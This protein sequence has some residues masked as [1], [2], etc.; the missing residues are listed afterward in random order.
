M[1]DGLLG[2]IDRT[3]EDSVQVSVMSLSLKTLREREM[4]M[5]NWAVC[6]WKVLKHLGSKVDY[7][8]RDYENTEFAFT[9][10]QSTLLVEADKL[11]R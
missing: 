4:E 9:E 8:K 10:Q 6:F 2:R 11:T 5:T 7:L 1:V 3:R